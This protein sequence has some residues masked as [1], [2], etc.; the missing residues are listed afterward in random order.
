MSLGWMRRKEKRWQRERMVAVSYTHLDVYKRQTQE[1][2]RARAVSMAQRVNWRVVCLIP[3]PPLTQD[4]VHA[5]AAALK[6]DDD[7]GGEA[8]EALAGL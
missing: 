5:V 7:P 1:R 4:R 2:A 6:L 8:N 3:A